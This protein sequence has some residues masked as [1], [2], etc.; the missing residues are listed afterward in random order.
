[1]LGKLEQKQNYNKNLKNKNLIFIPIF[2]GGFCNSTGRD[3]GV[4]VYM[5]N[6]PQFLTNN[7]L[8]FFT[9]IKK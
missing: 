2:G 5:K 9:L 1:M 3:V 6:P 4:Y 8:K 7:H